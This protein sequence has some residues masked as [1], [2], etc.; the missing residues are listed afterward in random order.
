MTPSESAQRL[1]DPI[2]TTKPPAE[3]D[4]RRTVTT[5][6]VAKAITQ[7][8][9]Q[10]GLSAAMQIQVVLRALDLTVVPDPEGP[11]ARTESRLSVGACAACLES[12][13]EANQPR[14]HTCW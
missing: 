5:S 6:Q 2:F 11:P 3:I 1:P 9:G 12:L 8:R 14:G 13:S 10:R 4:R 7:L